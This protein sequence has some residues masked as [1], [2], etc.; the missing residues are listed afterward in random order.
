MGS[1]VLQFVRLFH[2]TPSAYLWEDDEGEVHTVLQGEG[3]EQGD[4]LMPL[5][6]CVGQHSTLQAV[7]HSS[8][9]T[10]RLLAFLDDL[11]VV[12]KPDRVGAIYSIVQESLW[13][14]AGI[15]VHGGKT[16]V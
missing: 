13:G 16:H 2:S 9:P 15:R 4:A 8:R 1:A 7:Q 3:G 10:E 5:L 14:H 6:F 11:Y 12:S